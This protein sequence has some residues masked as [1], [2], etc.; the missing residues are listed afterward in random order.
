[1][2]MFTAPKL[3]LTKIFIVICCLRLVVPIKSHRHRHTHANH[4]PGHTN[5]ST[6]PRGACRFFV[7][8]GLSA[9]RYHLCNRLIRENLYEGRGGQKFVRIRPG[10]LLESLYS[11]HGK[12]GNDRCAI[13]NQPFKAHLA[14]WWFND[15]YTPYDLYLERINKQASCLEKD[16]VCKDTSNSYGGNL[17]DGLFM[18][19]KPYVTQMND[20]SHSSRMKTRG[21]SKEVSNADTFKMERQKNGG[22]EYAIPRFRSHPNDTANN[23][24]YLMRTIVLEEL[25]ILL[26]MQQRENHLK[27]WKDRHRL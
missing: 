26:H 22:I 12:H 11:Q 4:V 20:A 10:S 3:H 13:C 5:N 15:L 14:S 23:V 17:N 25:N 7:W 6:R 8:D 27:Q 18:F 21:K 9:L 16:E 1:M 19:H 24:L 2:T